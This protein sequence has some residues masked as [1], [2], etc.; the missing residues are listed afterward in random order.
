MTNSRIPAGYQRGLLCGF[1]YRI[2]L[3]S[4]HHFPKPKPEPEPF[5]AFCI[6]L[7]VQILC[8]CRLAACCSENQIPIATLRIRNAIFPQPGCWPLFGCWLLRSASVYISISISILPAIRVICLHNFG[9]LLLARLKLPS[10]LLFVVFMGG[11]IVTS[12]FLPSQFFRRAVSI[13][14][15][16]NSHY[17]P[18]A[19]TRTPLRLVSARVICP[20]AVIRR[21]R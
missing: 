10:L 20:V 15:Y 17:G 2:S 16:I 13:L 18:R 19:G 4:A 9:C 3:H 14:G 5:P 12:S 8:R 21:R 11:E 6:V 7:G 1:C